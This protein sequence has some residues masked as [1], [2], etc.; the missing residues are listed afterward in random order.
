MVRWRRCVPDAECD[1]I[2]PHQFPAVLRVRL[3]SGE[4]LEERVSVNRGG[5]GNPLSSEELAAKFRLNAT[6]LLTSEQ[7]DR[8]TELTYGLPAAPDLTALAEALRAAPASS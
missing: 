2:F 5:P 8:V 7:A 4:V 1:R 6:R 3:T